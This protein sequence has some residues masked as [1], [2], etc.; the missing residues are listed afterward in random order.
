MTTTGAGRDNDDS[1]DDGSADWKTGNDPRITTSG[2]GGDGNEPKLPNYESSADG[3]DGTSTPMIPA[4]GAAGDGNEPDNDSSTSEDEDD[5]MPSLTTDE[6]VTTANELVTSTTMEQVTTA[7]G[8]VPATSF[9]NVL[10][11]P[12]EKAQ[13]MPL[14]MTVGLL[15]PLVPWPADQLTLLIA[16]M[17]RVCSRLS[18]SARTT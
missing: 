10:P 14:R 11:D 15:V 18:R 17:Q 13:G 2:A 16:L 5:D 6:L 9:S 3:K 12:E 1:D 8:L 4:S 7:D